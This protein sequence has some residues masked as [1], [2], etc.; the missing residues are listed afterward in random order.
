MYSYILNIRMFYGIGFSGSERT[1]RRRII[2]NVCTD[3]NYIFGHGLCQVQTGVNCRR[4]WRNTSL[5]CDNEPSFKT[6]N[7]GK[8]LKF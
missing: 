4:N 5:C 2:F 7:T 6:Q 1:V 8:Q 3:H